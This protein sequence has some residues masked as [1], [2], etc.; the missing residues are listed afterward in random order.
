MHFTQGRH[1]PQRSQEHSLLV[2]QALSH[3][4]KT[5]QEGKQEKPPS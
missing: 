5:E 2:Y 4:P 1:T 3:S